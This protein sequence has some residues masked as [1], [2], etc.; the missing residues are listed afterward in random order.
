MEHIKLT[1]CPACGSTE[2]KHV[3]DVKDYFLTQE[4]FGLDQCSD[5]QL[6]FTNP[7]PA[8]DR[9]GDYYKS[10]AYVSHSST[11]KG[12]V[13]RVYNKVRSITLNQKLKLINSFASGKRLLDIGAGTGHFAAKMRDNGYAVTGLEPDSDARRV[14]M[15]LNQLELQP[16]EKL[17]APELGSFDVITMWH[18]L[19]HVYDLK[20]D[21]EQISSLLK[22]DGLLVIAVPNYT[23]YDA[24]YYGEF[25]AAYDVPRHLYHFE[26]TSLVPMIQKMNFDFVKMLPMKFDSYYVSMLSEKYK[27]GSIVNAVKTGWKSNSRSGEGKSSSQ[28]YIFKKK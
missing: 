1:Q 13:N 4:S 24:E 15:E 2:I 17:Y 3:R 5:C 23:S 12:V 16:L 10:E 14:C 19:E 7:R 20:K 21:L 18:V 22:K 27:G 9:I 26:P 25:W 11:K 8:P 28:I 6:V